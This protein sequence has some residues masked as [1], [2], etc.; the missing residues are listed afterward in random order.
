MR[1]RFLRARAASFRY[2]FRGVGALVETQHNAWFHALA[3]VVVA[4]AGLS[5]RLSRDEWCWI[6]LA[7]TVVWMAEALNTAIEFLADAA[8]PHQHPLVGKAKDVAAGAVL[9]AAIGAAVIG[10]LVFLPRLVKQLI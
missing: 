10:S 3:T 1:K 5:F 9:F 6:V 8:V 2:A 7:I 4:A